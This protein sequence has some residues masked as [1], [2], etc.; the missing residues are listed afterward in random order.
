VVGDLTGYGRSSRTAVPE[1][2]NPHLITSGHGTFEGPEGK[3]TIGPGDAFCLWPGVPHDFREDPDDSWHFYWMR[4]EGEQTEDVARAMGFAPDRRVRRPEDPDRAIRAFQALF[5]HYAADDRD[6]YRAASLF[7]EF[8]AACRKPEPRA[9][10][11]T[12]RRLVQEARA[13]V[14]SLLETGL[15]VSVLADHLHVTRQ[16]LLAAFK[17]ELDTTPTEYIQQARLERAQRLLAETELKIGAVSRACGYGNEKYFYRRF[18]ELTSHTPGE[19]RQ[20]GRE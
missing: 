10:R 15:N 20:R 13:L 12:D 18:R 11:N 14:E 6:A 17:A 7:F 1:T 9:A 2:F 5:E 4:M 16:A 3:V 19:W 8:V